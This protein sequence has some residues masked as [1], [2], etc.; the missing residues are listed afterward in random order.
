[1]PDEKLHLLADSAERVAWELAQEIHSWE[2]LE[3]S[4]EKKYDRKYWLTLYRQCARV[5]VNGTAV[6]NVIPDDGKD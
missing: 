2:K 3:E 6:N 1:M 4:D 5:V